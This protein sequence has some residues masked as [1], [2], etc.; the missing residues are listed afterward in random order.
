MGDGWLVSVAVFLGD[1]WLVASAFGVVCSEMSDC[2][3][4]P[5][6][7]TEIGFMSYGP[8]IVE[9]FRLAAAYVDKLLKGAK[10]AVN[11]PNSSWPS[12]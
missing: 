5:A 2:A 6:D 1:V 9:S 7:A 10:P 4:S 8:D 11:Q 3:A 12:I